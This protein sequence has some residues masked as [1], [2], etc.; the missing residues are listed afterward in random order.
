MTELTSVWPP[1]AL[2]LTTPRLTLR[3]LRD[4]DI[5]SAVEAALAAS[6]N[7]AATR[8]ALH[9]RSRR[10]RS[11][12]QHGPVVLAVPGQHLAGGLD[13]APG[14]LA[15]RTRSSAAR[16]WR[17]RTSQRSRQSA[18]AHGSGQ[19]RTAGASARRCAPPS[20]STP[21][22]GSEPKWRSPKPQ[23]G[24]QPSL[25]VSRVP[26]LRTQRHHPHA[27]GRQDGDSAKRP[28]HPG[29]LQPPRLAPKSRRPRTHGQIPRNRRAPRPRVRQARPA[30]L[31]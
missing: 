8:S 27:V 18:P 21:S 12:A 28:P 16:T 9:G 3:P 31:H 19:A 2:T 14:H 23:P 30:V 25:G 13:P 29:N 7:P 4:D 1:F 10:R 17:P 15:R 11:G 20:R 24:T 26:R 6:T 22:T 5:P